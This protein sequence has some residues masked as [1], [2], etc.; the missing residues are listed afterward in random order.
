M[1]RLSG[2]TTKNEIIQVACENFFERGY[3]ATSPKLIASELGI[4]PGNLTYHFPTKEHLLTVVVH[5]LCQFQWKLLGIEAEK[6][7]DSVGSV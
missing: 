1:A 5:M 6:G 4:S 3:S 7:I 2:I